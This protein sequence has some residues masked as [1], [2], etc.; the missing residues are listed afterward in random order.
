MLKI[1][2]LSHM[3]SIE[4]TSPPCTPP[5]LSK[6]EKLD[7]PL[8][9]V[10]QVVLLS[11]ISSNFFLSDARQLKE[12]NCSIEQA[13]EKI[14]SLVYPFFEIENSKENLSQLPP[15][16][17]I[18]EE[19]WPGIWC[20]KEKSDSENS[21]DEDTFALDYLYITLS[22]SPIAAEA[23]TP[24]LSILASKIVQYL[25]FTSIIVKDPHPTA[26]TGYMPLS[27]INQANQEAF[28][29]TL[30]AAESH[31]VQLAWIQ[32]LANPNQFPEKIIDIDPIIIV[33]EKL[34]PSSLIAL[35]G[36][37]LEEDPGD[38]AEGGFVTVSPPPQRAA[39]L[40]TDS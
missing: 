40:K 26:H 10:R 13:E 23:Q 30:K 7:E 6:D 3:S 34:D 22:P 11:N 39:L 8:L 24:E 27:E 2:R 12:Q 29:L 15:R 33:D 4:R 32:L 21:E 1:T 28:E 17:M 36:H 14:N 18:Q 37:L 5:P 16:I 25:Q 35:G 19:V 38:A 20:S 31:K 9:P